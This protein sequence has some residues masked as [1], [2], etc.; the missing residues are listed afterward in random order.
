MFS[1]L[2][3]NS[4]VELPKSNLMILEKRALLSSRSIPKQ[5]KTNM[6]RNA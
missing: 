2:L 3:D 4:F 6:N 5:G 1:I